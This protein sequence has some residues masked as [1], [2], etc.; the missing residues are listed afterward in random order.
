MR[1]VV[2]VG[3]GQTEET[4]V[5]DFLGPAL[6]NGNLFVCPRLIHTSPRSRGGALTPQRVLGFLR[7]TLR[8]RKDTYVTTFFDLYG[9]HPDFPGVSRAARQPDPLKRATAVE[10]GFHET[11]IQEAGCRSDRFLPHIQPYEFEA[12]L[13]SDTGRFAETEP[14]WGEFVGELEHA[15]RSVQSPEHINDGRDTHPSARLKRL[16]GPRYGK[17]RHGIAVSR[18]IG[19]SQIRAEVPPF[20][21]M[22]ETIGGPSTVATDG[23]IPQAA[24]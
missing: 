13:F 15:R 2:V 8:E 21:P 16:S 23:V 18:R 4:F 11:V 17:V 20:R 6:A 9:L 14:A 1:E 24:Q 22:A 19:L 5:R 10:A 12:L 7:N 3:E